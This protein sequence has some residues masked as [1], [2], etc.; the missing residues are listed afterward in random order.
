MKL[1]HLG[2]GILKEKQNKECN[3]STFLSVCSYPC[4]TQMIVCHVSG[5]GNRSVSYQIYYLLRKKQVNLEFNNADSLVA[6]VT[7]EEITPC[8]SILGGVI[9]FAPRNDNYTSL[10]WLTLKR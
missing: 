1:I 5:S 8:F 7:R 9:K 4:L 10:D 3:K 2:A 6:S